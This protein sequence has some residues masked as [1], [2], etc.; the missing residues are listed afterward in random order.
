MYISTSGTA[1]YINNIIF[2]DQKKIGEE[3][4]NCFVATVKFG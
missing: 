3:V 4:F 2:A 1:F